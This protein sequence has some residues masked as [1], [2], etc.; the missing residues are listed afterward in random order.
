MET[1]QQELYSSVLSEAVVDWGNMGPGEEWVNSPSHE[2]EKG[3]QTSVY[4]SDNRV[5]ST[6]WDMYLDSTESGLASGFLDSE[7]LKEADEDFA[8]EVNFNNSVMTEEEKQEI[9]QEL[10]KLEEEISTLRQVLSSKEKQ[11][12][13]LR[14]KLGITPLSELRNNFSRGWHDMQ[15]SVAYKK[16]SETFSTAGQKTS[17]AFSTLG[18]TITRKFGDMSYSIKHSMS[19]PAMRN[20]QSF[21]SFEEKVENTVSTIKT[22]VGA[23]ETRGSFEEVLSSTANASAQD[24]PTN[25]LTDC[26][27]KAC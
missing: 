23:T 6:T 22:K 20:S 15:T 5:M 2:G 24:P 16:T 9:H 26:S 27:E 18:S 1:R 17:A 11:H 13:D 4:H 25:N 3:H 14:H 10:T 21:K 19:M 12:A 7:P 8:S